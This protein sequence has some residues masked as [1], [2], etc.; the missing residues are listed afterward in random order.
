MT[1]TE[2][3]AM[4]AGLTVT[5]V[6]KRY[7]TPPTQLNTAQLPAQWPRLPGG[8]TQI[9]TLTSGAGLPA[10][11]CD[12][13]IAV[14]AYGQ[15]TQPAN[16]AKAVAVVDALN[17]ALLTEAA[18]GVIDGWA[19]RLEVDQIGDVAYWVIVATVTGSE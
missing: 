3:V 4:L 10:M 14:E 1:Y 15:N 19:L 11:A 8:E 12:L 13:V 5:G 16:Y 17:T 6:V 9:I 18:D 2:Y 7:P